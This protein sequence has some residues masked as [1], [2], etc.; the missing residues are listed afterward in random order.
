MSKLTNHL[1][2][3]A[4][5]PR[6]VLQFPVTNA[7]MFF[8]ELAYHSYVSCGAPLSDPPFFHLTDHCCAACFYGKIKD[9]V[10]AMVLQIHCKFKTFC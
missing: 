2:E 5:L 8:A 4:S 10:K 6:S 7:S 3:N 1:H 9:V